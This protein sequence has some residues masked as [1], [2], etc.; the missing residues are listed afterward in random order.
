MKPLTTILSLPVV[1]PPTKANFY[2]NDLGLETDGVKNGIVA[3][4]LPHLSIFFIAAD[5][6][7]QYLELPGQPG[8]KYPVP[9]ASIV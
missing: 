2:A 6:Y 8:S 7:G 9:G 4:E 3:F 5:E 1:D